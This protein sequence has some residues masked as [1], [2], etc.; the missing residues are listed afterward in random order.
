MLRQAERSCQVDGVIAAKVEI[1]GEIPGN[2]GELLVDTDGDQ[3]LAD[4]LELCN[5]FAGESRG[6]SVTS[7]RSRQRRSTLGISEK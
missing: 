4:L 1:R 2:P 7:A 5:G 3:L 6:Q